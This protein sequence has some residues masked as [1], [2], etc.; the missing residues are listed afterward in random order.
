MYPHEDIGNLPDYVIIINY[1][2][3]ILNNNESKNIILNR[4]KIYTCYFI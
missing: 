4:N 2:I 3:I 1:Y